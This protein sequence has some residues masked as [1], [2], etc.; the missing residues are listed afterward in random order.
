L[1]TL[2]VLEAC[3]P[4]TDLSDE[5]TRNEIKEETK[6]ALT[7]NDC[8]AALTLI[9]PLY[10]S[11]YT[12]NETRMLYASAQGCSAGINFFDIFDELSG[13]SISG[14]AL[15]QLTTQLFPSVAATDAKLQADWFAQEAL[16]SVWV[17]GAIVSSRD[18]YNTGTANP[19]SILYRDRTANSNTFLLFVAMAGIGIVQNQ[20]GYASGQDPAAFS[21]QQQVDFPW[22]S[23]ALVE[24]DTTGVACGLA[25]SVLNLI[26]A[27][28]AL[29][30]TSSNLGSSLSDIQTTLGAIE[31]GA[32]LACTLDGHLSTTCDQAVKRLRYGAS[33]SEDPSI[34]A[35][36]AS[37]VFAVNSLWP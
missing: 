1:L 28:N 12:D 36:A 21:Y 5:T 6:N 11:E 4:G 15:F 8:V 13:G 34:A 29:I 23:R 20:Y 31:A 17:T 27:S 2:L 7:T 10:V 30:D 35:A 26:D 9:S 19:A 25:S 33:C 18:S 3:S 14:G 32:S 37:I 22:V 24:S 16:H